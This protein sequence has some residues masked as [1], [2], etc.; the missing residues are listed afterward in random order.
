MSMG[1]PF[2]G[3]IPLEPEIV[4]MGDAGESYF[5]KNPESETGKEFSRIV[6]KIMKAVKE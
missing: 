1:V 3:K 6:D 4:K 2:L 5:D